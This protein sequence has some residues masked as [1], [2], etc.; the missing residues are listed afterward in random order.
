MICP[1]RLC[2]STPLLGLEA[3]L[4]ALA[5]SQRRVRCDAT[6]SHQ[7]GLPAAGS[8]AAGYVQPL[9]HWLTAAVVNR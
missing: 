3:E 7:R 5:L 9:I 8:S 2:G 4:S 1:A 6:L